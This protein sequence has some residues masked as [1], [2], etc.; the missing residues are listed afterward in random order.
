MENKQQ[1]EKT[2][3]PN[4]KNIIMVASGKGGVGKSTIASGLALSLSLEGFNVGLFDAD[5]YGPSIPTLFNLNNQRP[6]VCDYGEKNLIEPFDKMGIKVMSIGFFANP[7]QALIWRGP[8]ASNAL[9]QLIDETNWGDLD[10][11][12]IDSPPGTGDIHITMLQQYEVSGALIVTTPQNV[13]IADVQKAISMF[14]K[15]DIGVP[16]I[17]LIE[18]MAW[19][20]PQAHPDEKYYLFGQGGGEFLSDKFN[21]PLLTQIPFTEN[22]CQSCDEGKLNDILKNQSVK[23]GF[24]QLVNKIL[25]A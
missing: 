6:Y 11:L 15:N 21:I 13:A 1:I 9:K 14:L 7:S 2:I 17:G 10:Y 19:F 24:D 20:T 4:I 23:K 3:F 18:N 25:K 22:M 12:I 8:M 16:V 5:I